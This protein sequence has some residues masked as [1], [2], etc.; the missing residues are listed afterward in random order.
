MRQRILSALGVPLFACFCAV[1]LLVAAPPGA[2]QDAGALVDRLLV[3]AGPGLSLHAVQTGTA[4]LPRDGDGQSPARPIFS[5]VFA[6]PGGRVAARIGTDGQLRLLTGTGEASA[7]QTRVQRNTKAD[8]DALVAPQQHAA[9][10]VDVDRMIV[11]PISLATFAARFGV[12]EFSRPLIAATPRQ[13]ADEPEALVEVSLPAEALRAP[14]SAPS[15]GA[16][17]EIVES[18]SSSETMTQRLRF[19]A[20]RSNGDMDRARQCLAEAIYFES[21]G[22]PEMGQLAVAQV[23]LNRVMSGLYPNS[24]CGVVYQNAHRFNACQFS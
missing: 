6:D 5:A 3:G 21:R 18:V 2:R 16:P 13:A 15:R 23:V 17:P 7:S 9:A 19:L 4:L 12:A 8:R 22:E 14:D 11:Q 10:I 20:I 1:P 24:V